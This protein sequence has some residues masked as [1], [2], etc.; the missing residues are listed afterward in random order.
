MV[1]GRSKVCRG[2]TRSSSWTR[3]SFILALLGFLLFS[4]IIS[5]FAQDPSPPVDQ[6]ITDLNLDQ[7]IDRPLSGGEKQTFRLTLRA[8]QVFTVVIRQ[9]GTEAGVNLYL[10]TGQSVSLYQPYSRLPEIRFGW[11]AETSGE[12]MV[13]IYSRERA[14]PGRY[15][16]RLTDLHAASDRDRSLQEA[17]NL[18]NDYVRLNR[19]SRF[20]DSRIPLQRAL[21]IREK[22]LGPNDLLVGVTLAYLAANYSASGDYVNA[23]SMKLRALKIMEDKLGPDSL[24]VANELGELGAFYRAKGDL[25]KS[26]ELYRRA[27]VILERN[28]ELDG[29]VVAGIFGTMGSIYYQR[30]DYTKAAKYYELSRA[31]WEKLLG[32]DH[33]HMAP[34]YT[35]LG[36]AAYDSGDYRKA[37]QMFQRALELTEKGL[38]PNNTRISRYL[39]DLAMVNCTTGEFSLGESNYR[40]A[41]AIQESRTALGQPE[42]QETL[43]G[44]ARCYAAQGIKQ[45][46]I[47]MQS[48]ASDLAERFVALNL[49]VGAEREKLAF[50]DTFA[51]RLSRNISL[52]ADF[53]PG[54]PGARELALTSILQRKGRVQ[55]AMSDS[56]AALRQRSQPEDRTQIE[57]LND[58][59]S[60]LAGLVLKGPLE[61][62]PA[63]YQSRILALESERDRY[64]DEL[65]RR[66]AGF[67]SRPLPVTVEAV[68]SALPAD[69]ALVE[70]AVYSPFDPRSPDN[71]RAYGK[72]NY[73]AYVLRPAGE[74]RWVQ[75]GDVA[76]IDSLIEAWRKAL[77]DPHRSEVRSLARTLDEKLMRPVRLLTGDARHLLLS[78]DGALNL[79]PFAALVDEGQRYLIQRFSFTYLTSGRDL[80]RM[81][82][83]RASKSAPLVIA[84]PRFAEPTPG[85][86]ALRTAA[87][88]PGKGKG[89]SVTTAG[90]LSA[91]YFAPLA[92]TEVEARSIARLFPDAALLMGAQATEAALK[93]VEAPRLLHIATHGYFLHDENSGQ[94]G[95]SQGSASH[96]R[97]QVPTSLRANPLLRSGLAL[98]D[99]N[100]RK[101]G[102]DDGILTALEASGLNLWG[103]KLVVL[104]ACD[105]GLGEV[106]VGE[107]VYGLRRAFVLAG[108]ESLVMSLWPISDFTTRQLMNH[109]YER[110]QQGE[111]RGGALRNVQL[112]MLQ[113]DPKLHPFYWANFIQ[114][115]EWA[116][117]SGQR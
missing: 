31:A 46:A 57:H 2:K 9:S 14:A 63:E 112:E 117:L 61:L 77:R 92:G 16:I 24:R 38:G 94:E 28:R 76:S 55:D 88:R 74:I 36:R 73:V 12:Y 34:F 54:D 100:L 11:L 107:G 47:Q 50:L 17:R 87:L 78:P 99:A 39:N 84:N 69:S 102:S 41:L 49:S 4:S 115:G 85:V 53:A 105:T 6:A 19:E 65:S 104:S 20:T 110:L 67:Y 109:Y 71:A 97:D 91:V 96:R 10:P 83:P 114:A 23:E 80:L 68:R 48:R 56:L 106:H 29:P 72:P 70:F 59:N 18:F 89:L 60:R 27:L 25:F 90:E 111:G 21:E 51:R 8:E 33:F 35:Y 81:Q 13:E 45:E 22:I 52:H 64:E 98:A 62:P 26:E 116:N 93:R 42:T 103:T 58:A 108:A 5:T 37:G 86:V 15:E 75:L 3:G 95:I 30:A 44:L 43:Q 7:A 32:P 82:V 40:R 113:R 1:T 101:S 79:L 66:S